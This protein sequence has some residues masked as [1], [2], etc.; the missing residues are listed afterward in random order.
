MANSL[1]SDKRFLEFEGLKALIIKIGALREEY[2]TKFD[3]IDTANGELLARLD[4]LLK[5]ETDLNGRIGIS[6]GKEI[7]VAIV[8]FIEAMRAELGDAPEEISQTI[9]QR[10]EALEADCKQLNTR[11]D[12]LEN[13]AL[14]SVAAEYD[15]VNN[16]IRVGFGTTKAEAVTSQESLVPNKSFTIDTSD[17]VIDGLLG[18]VHSVTVVTE[19]P[20]KGAFEFVT[21][22]GPEGPT[23]E[24]KLIR[25]YEDI[26]ADK[27]IDGHRYL[28]FSFKVN[29]TD[30]EGEATVE[31]E[32]DIWVDLLDIHD[33]FKFKA[34]PTGDPYI[35]LSV[36]TIHNASASTDVTYTVSA[37]DKA[38]EDFNIVEGNHIPDPDGAPGVKNRGVLQLDTDLK[39]AEKDIDKLQEEIETPET[40]LL[41]KV[42]T[43]ED[44]VRNGWT[45]DESNEIPGL[46]DRTTALEKWTSENIVTV[47][48]INDYFDYWVMGD[49]KDPDDPSDEFKAAADKRKE[50]LANIKKD[51]V[52]VPEL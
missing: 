7:I 43:L 27:R 6:E 23:V 8:E 36:E 15:R 38:V 49:V 14:T 28:V 41:D 19:G 47:E 46:L 17:F 20:E 40:G 24:K 21:V 13:N 25:A 30:Q 1:V 35:N 11:I 33:N 31:A 52:Q 34:V 9:Y 50:T 12:A 37:G 29:E 42:K 10:L 32:K 48:E 3:E 5:A 45:D 4:K 16:Q 51:F 26:P 44:E 2:L 39:A 22:E 18:D